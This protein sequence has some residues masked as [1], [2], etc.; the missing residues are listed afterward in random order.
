M[1]ALTNDLRRTVTEMEEE[2]LSIKR[3]TDTSNAQI[4]GIKDECLLYRDGVEHVQTQMNHLAQ[5][6]IRYELDI[7]NVKR[8]MTSMDE[9]I[10][11]LQVSIQERSTRGE[12]NARVMASIDPLRNQMETALKAQSQAVATATATAMSAAHKAQ[13]SAELV[14]SKTQYFLNDNNQSN[15]TSNGNISSTIHNGTNNQPSNVQLE[16]IE[17]RIERRME[18]IL[19]DKIELSMA[20]LKS[21]LEDDFKNN[22]GQQQQQ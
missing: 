18:R 1:F 19:E 5:R 8:T 6:G 20:R 11:Q 2:I 12:V 17:T 7:D 9:T 22:N 16:I 13:A 4:L 15:D 3:N 21:K 10:R 14:E